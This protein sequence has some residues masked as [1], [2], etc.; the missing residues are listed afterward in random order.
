MRNL[1]IPSLAL[2]VTLLLATSC[3]DSFMDRQPHTEIGV[4]SYFNTERDLQM[5][6][7]GLV[8]TPGYSYDSDEGTDDVATTSNVEIKNIMTSPNPNS[9]TINAGWSWER[10]YDINFFLANCGRAKVTEDVLAHYQ[11]VARYYRAAFYMDKV[12]TYSDVPWYDK[13]LTT[14]DPDLYKA[15]DSRDFVIGKIFEDY[16]FA[17]EH[18][19]ATE[20]LGAIN[21]WIVLATMARHALYEGTYRKYHDELNL[22]QTAADYLRMAADAAWQVMQEGGFSI[23]NTGHPYEDY[24]TLFN[25]PDLTTNPEMIQAHYYE[26]DVAENG[27]W[28]YMFGNYIPCPTKDLVQA[29]L[30]KDG[31]YYSSQPDYR[32]RQFVDEFKDRDPRIYQTLA[33]PGWELVNTMTYATGAG[34]YVQEL[35][36]NFSGYH[37]IKGF[38]NNKDENYYVGIDFPVI[39]YA[40]VLLTYAEAKAELGELTQDVLDQ[41]VNLLRD[42]AGMPHLQMNPPVDPVMA[43]AFPGVGSTLL[44]IRRERRVEL[45]FE[46]FRFDDLMRWHAGKLLEHEPEGLY[47]PSLGKFDLTGDGIEDICLIPSSQSIPAEEDKETNALGEKLVYYRAGTIDDQNATVYLSDGDHGTIQTIKDMGTFQEPKF[48]Y[49]PI[50]RHEMDLNPNLGPQLFGWE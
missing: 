37:Q 25:S 23:Y 46:G 27:F 26:N 45:A 42:R 24:S 5:Y 9:V 3:N 15:R 39:R 50:P 44:E 28:A 33:Y 6:C 30:M 1:I 13:V 31:S 14:D 7:Y 10:L 43:E 11:G 48:Y 18:V 38:I 20:P 22:Q 29:Y 2:S 32:T 34:I 49:R 19:R 36:K 16:Q 47:F 41:T 17:A 12:K 4:E 21:K 35:N 40:E 8:N